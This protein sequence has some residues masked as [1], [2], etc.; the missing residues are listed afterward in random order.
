[1]PFSLSMIAHIVLLANFLTGVHATCHVAPLGGNHELLLKGNVLTTKGALHTGYVYIRS[2]KIADVGSQCHLARL[3]AETQ[4]ATIIECNNAVISPGFIN[5]H[6]H[7]AYSTVRPLNY[8]GELYDH[9]HDWRVG[10]RNHTMLDAPVNG[11]E[12]DA[13][14]WGELRHIFSGTTSIVGGYMSPGLTRNLDFVDGLEDGISPPLDTWSVFPLD[15]SP[16]TLRNGDCDYGT[17]AVDATSVGKA[18][19]FMGHVAEGVDAE[20][21][22]EFKCLSSKTFDVTPR[23]DGSGV[24]VDIMAPNVVLE[25]AVGLTEE[26][27]DLVAKRGAKVVWA[28]RSNIFLYGKTLNVTYLLNAGIKVA[29]GTDWLPSGSATMSREAA[30]A[31]YAT[32]KSYDF[33]LEAKTIWEMMT[34]NAAKVAGFERHLGSIEPGKA[35]DVVIFSGEMDGDAYSQAIY[36]PEEDIELVMRGGKILLAA[37][38]LKPLTTSSCETLEFGN[39]TKIACVKDELNSTF[40]DFEASL[41]GV[42]PAILPGVPPDEPMCDPSR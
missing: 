25:H 15:D 16:G 34:I 11:T 5:L 39:T 35:A 21:R 42:Y 33:V 10:A 12:A 20:A 6:E 24:S 17:N 4:N 36:S 37:E 2:G 40:L 31:L 28:P 8:T 38:S 29:L 32:N 13:T 19:R 30:C 9:R 26:D 41:Q 22:N 3:Q 1:M 14:T 23:T 18:Y 7:I 27:F